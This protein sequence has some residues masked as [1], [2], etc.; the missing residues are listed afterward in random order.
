MS[1]ASKQIKQRRVPTKND[2]LRAAAADSVRESAVRTGKKFES[3]EEL[4]DEV[5]ICLRF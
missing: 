5:R 2:S 1:G 3:V 4:I